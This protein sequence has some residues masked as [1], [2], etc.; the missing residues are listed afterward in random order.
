MVPVCGAAMQAEVAVF[1][2]FLADPLMM[3]PG[4]RRS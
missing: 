4:A 3:R 1:I 2:R